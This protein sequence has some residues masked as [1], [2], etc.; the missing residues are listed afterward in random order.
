MRYADD[1]VLMGERIT[2]E[3]LNKVK[4]VNRKYGF[5]TKRRKDK[6]NKCKRK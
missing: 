4:E 1:F 6:T 5:E 2:E 3:I